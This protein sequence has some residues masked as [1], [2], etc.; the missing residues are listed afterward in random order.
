MGLPSPPPVP[1]PSA[2]PGTAAEVLT[3]EELLRW[4]RSLLA[5]GGRRADLDWL[6]DR[7]GGLSWVLLQQLRLHPERRLLLC[8]GTRAIEAIWRH[9]LATATPLQ[10]LVGTCPW[11]DFNLSVGAGVLIPR[12]ETELLPD[13]AITLL[14]PSLDPAAVLWADLGTGSGCL[15]LALAAGLPGSRG[16]AVDVSPAALAFATANIAAA[17][18]DGRVTPLRSDWWTNLRPWW[19]KLGL[20]VANPP[21]IPSPLVPTLEPVVRDHEPILALDG[22]VDGL[23]AIRPVVAGAAVGLAEEGVIVIEHHHDQSDAVCALLQEAGLEA[24]SAHTDLEGVRRF[25]SARRCGTRSGSAP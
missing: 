11:R 8:R 5:T 23:S 6:L 25:A 12:Q 20:V 1:L 7:A 3:G 15:A 24:V 2:D 9:H 13:L 16:L 17:G 22:G 14:K 19:G 18:L 10:Y 21:Y 4:R